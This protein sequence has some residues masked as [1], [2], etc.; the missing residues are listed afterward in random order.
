[1]SLFGALAACAPTLLACTP[2]DAHVP[3]FATRPYEAISR[4]SVVAIAL[5]EWRLFGL[6]VQDSE[7]AG[8]PLSSAPNAGASSPDASPTILGGAGAGEP[9]RNAVYPTRSAQDVI[10]GDFVGSADGERKAERLPGLW[11]RVGEY[12][13]IGLDAGSPESGWTGK[14]DANGR[15]FPPSDDAAHAWSAAFI[16]YVMRIAGA[17]ARFPYAPDHADYINAS[18]RRDAD[19]VVA[20]E[21]PES[22]AP[23]PGDLICRGRG[24]AVS[25]RF[26]DLPARHFPAH[27]DIVVGTAPNRLL[28]I[29]G[30]VD[31]AVTLRAV[32]TTAEGRLARP[33]GMVVDPDNPWMVVLRLTVAGDAGD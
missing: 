21:P 32:P 5:R 24:W 7:P 19:W 26:A 31:D 12:W 16:S 1:V 3:P 6:R 23:V 29:G 18:C 30:N 25:L 2:P 27:C 28:V 11:Q 9:L 13:W 17:G 33:D 14:H 10:A 22:Y 15:V 8:A 4:R 20:A